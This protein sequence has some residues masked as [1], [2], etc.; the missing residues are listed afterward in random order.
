MDFYL[1]V[2]IMREG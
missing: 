2:G 1:V